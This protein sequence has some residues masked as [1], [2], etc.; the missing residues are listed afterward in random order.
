MKNRAITFVGN[1]QLITSII[2]AFCPKDTWEKSLNDWE[3]KCITQGEL[4]V[5]SEESFSFISCNMGILGPIS[6]S[7][8]I[9]N[10][11]NEKISFINLIDKKTKAIVVML[12]GNEF[13]LHSL[14]DSYPRWDFTYQSALA[15]KGRQ[16][17]SQQDALEHFESVM[18]PMLATCLLYKQMFTNTKIFYVVPPP[19]IE[20]I[21]HILENPEGFRELFSEFGIMPFEIRKKIY[22]A[23]Y[24]PLA[25]RLNESNI[26][27]VFTPGECLTESGG[28]K[29]NYASGCLHGNSLYGKAIMTELQ[30][31][32]INA[33]L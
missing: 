11:S 2:A 6:F 17:I 33:S 23:M 7:N 30:K 28:L 20:D 3:A 13:A 19:P 5:D 1:S 8:G 18:N 14:V 25:V 10:C 21:N 22:D 9:V 12:R 26:E 4:L 24:M 16:L 29:A 32:G 15:I 31:R 27:T